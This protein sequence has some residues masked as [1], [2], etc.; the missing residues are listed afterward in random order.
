VSVCPPDLTVAQ[1][2]RRI[3]RDRARLLVVQEKGRIGVVWPADLRRAEAFGLADRSL[4]DV[5]V[6][7]VPT[8]SGEVPEVRVRRLLLAGVPVVLIREH[9]AV[10][11]AVE[12]SQLRR[13]RPT[14]SLAGRLARGVPEET[15]GLLSAVG[16]LSEFLNV[17]TFVAGGFVRDLLR[18]APSHDLDLVVEGDAVALARQL[19]GQLGGNLLVHRA[20]G[21]ASIEGWRGGRVDLATARREHYA[22]PGALPTVTSASIEADLA[23]RDFTVN[24]MALALTGSAFGQLL[25]PYGGQQDLSTRRLRILHPLSFVEDPTRIFRAARYAARLGLI[26]NRWTG[27]CLSVALDLGPYP[28]LSGQRLLAELEL[29]LNEP[30]WEEVLLTL[31]R[32]GAFRLLDPA[33][34]FSSAAAGRIRDLRELLRRGRERGIALDPLP[35]ALLC[36]VGHLPAQ[37][38]ERCLRRLALSGERLA[39]L[40]DACAQ[41]PLVARRLEDHAAAPASQRAAILRAQT[42]ETLGCAWLIGSR[43]VR[44]QV[45]WFLGEGRGVR[46]L[47]R[48]ADLLALGVSRGPAVSHFLHRLRDHRLDGLVSSREDEVRCVRRW[49]STRRGTSTPTTEEE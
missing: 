5:A 36:V 20:F 27:R 43:I 44:N 31:G 14:L 49:M 12:P 28:A 11:A 15:F 6:W 24:A 1:A 22:A 40:L 29:I 33:H 42:T 25:D 37:L 45:Q 38:A 30:E 26:V 34:R 4:G 35:L 2:R 32:F 47:L 9:D 21:T 10:V 3:E 18:G 41:G 19:C 39:R 7:G 13:M 48:G 23:R 46:P 17:R 16:Q 8:L